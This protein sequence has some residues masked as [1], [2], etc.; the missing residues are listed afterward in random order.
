MTWCQYKLSQCGYT[1]KMEIEN[2]HEEQFPNMNCVNRKCKKC[3]IRLLERRIHIINEKRV[4]FHN[5]VDWEQWK[6]VD[7]K[8]DIITTRNTLSTLLIDYLLHLEK[9]SHHY[10]FDV[11]MSHQLNCL[12]VAWTGSICQ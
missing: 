4:N 10:F 3:G 7:K 1:K 12:F 8:L 9:M 5:L 11:W 6:N 2:Q